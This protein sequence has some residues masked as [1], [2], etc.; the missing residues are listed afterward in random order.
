MSGAVYII[1]AKRKELSENDRKA[2]KPKGSKKNKE[3]QYPRTT[4]PSAETC[5][6]GPRDRYGRRSCGEASS[7][8]GPNEGRPSR[9]RELWGSGGSQAQ[10]PLGK[11]GTSRP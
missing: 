3:P 8:T 4:P 5:E 9:G 10:Q 7:N 1:L 6:R 2:P 11:Q